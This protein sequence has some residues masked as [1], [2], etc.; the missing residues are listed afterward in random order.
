[1]CLAN[2]TADEVTEHVLEA[3]RGGAAGPHAATR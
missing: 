3:W 2:V 1:M